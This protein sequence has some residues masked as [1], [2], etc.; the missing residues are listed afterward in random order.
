ME[1]KTEGKQEKTIPEITPE[2]VREEIRRIRLEIAH[3]L[4]EYKKKYPPPDEKTLGRVV[5]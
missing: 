4:E 2:R 5:Y 3:D 1:N